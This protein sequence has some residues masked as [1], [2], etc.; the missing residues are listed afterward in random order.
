M[1]GCVLSPPAGAPGFAGV[2][3]ITLVPDGSG[4]YTSTMPLAPTGCAKSETADIS[5]KFVGGAVTGTYKVTTT[6][7][8]CS[9]TLTAT[10]TGTKT[11]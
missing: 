9:G 7:A 11:G 1:G 10:I 3:S 8:N 2:S 6:G 5:V 4:G